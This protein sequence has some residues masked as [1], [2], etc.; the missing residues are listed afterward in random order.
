MFLELLRTCINISYQNFIFMIRIQILVFEIHKLFPSWLLVV[1]LCHLPDLIPWLIAPI[2][3]GD[4]PPLGGQYDPPQIFLPHPKLAVSVLQIGYYTIMYTTL[5]T[6]SM[7][8]DDI[9]KYIFLNENI[10]IWIK[11]SLKFVSK[12]SINNIPALVQVMAWCR[13]GDK[14]LSE[15]MMDNLPMHICITRPQ[16]VNVILKM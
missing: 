16:W 1:S 10:W 14:P 11:I 5:S 2:S 4:K 9:F 12:G 7:A 3:L 6:E 15:P 13:L 8:T